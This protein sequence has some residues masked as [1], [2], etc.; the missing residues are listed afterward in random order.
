MPLQ[1][2]VTPFGDIEAVA[3]RGSLMGN[4]GGRLHHPLARTLGARRW[5]SRQWICCR[6]Q[7]KGRRRQVMGAS[8]TEL[9]FLDEVTALAAGHR[10]CFECRREAALAFATAWAVAGGEAL[11][12]RANAMDLRLHAERLQGRS[13]RRHLGELSGLADGVMIEIDG[14]AFAVRG[15]KLLPWSHRGYGAP[16]VRPAGGEVVLLTPP[17]TIAALAAGYR[18]GWHESAEPSVS[19]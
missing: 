10:P 18:A 8:Y 19:G 17:A 1:N 2:R 9:F 4:R 16:L 5:A 15:G 14:Q 13:K 3:A 12:P 7:F 11:R 6:L